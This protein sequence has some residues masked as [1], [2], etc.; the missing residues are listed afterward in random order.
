[1][2]L[3]L[4][5]V[6]ENSAEAALFQNMQLETTNHKEIITFYMRLCKYRGLEMSGDFFGAQLANL[7]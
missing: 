7:G 4:G 6:S 3:S 1:M 2:E 5:R